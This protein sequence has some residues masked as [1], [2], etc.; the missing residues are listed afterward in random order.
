MRC[1]QNRARSTLAQYLSQ[2][3]YH[4]V[5]LGAMNTDS[6]ERGVLIEAQVGCPLVLFLDLTLFFDGVVF[7][8]KVLLLAHICFGAT[9]SYGPGV[10]MPKRVSTR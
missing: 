6:C 2:L 1:V 5:C 8:Y 7:D 10:L 9:D 3:Q 4:M